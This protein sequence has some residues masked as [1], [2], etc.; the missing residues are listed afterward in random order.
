VTDLNEKWEEPDPLNGRFIAVDS[1]S[2]KGKVILAWVMPIQRLDS[3]DPRFMRFLKGAP[4]DQ[5]LRLAQV[6]GLNRQILDAGGPLMGED[7]VQEFLYPAERDTVEESKPVFSEVTLER[8]WTLFQERDKNPDRYAGALD[9]AGH[10]LCTAGYP[11]LS[12]GH[13]PIVPNL[14]HEAILWA[15]SNDQASVELMGDWLKVNYYKA[16]T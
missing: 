13:E 11:T 8:V 2:E 15:I 5:A 4:G 9:V 1:Y 3:G 14:E 6:E 10:V 16:V 12:T 7:Q